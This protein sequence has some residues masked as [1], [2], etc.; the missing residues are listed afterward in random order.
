MGRFTYSQRI[1]FPEVLVSLSK[2]EKVEDKTLNPS[3]DFR[4]R[5]NSQKWL[6][7]RLN[8]AA[9]SLTEPATDPKLFEGINNY[10]HI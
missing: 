8:S 10:Y 9:W 2:C 3:P 1:R 6:E 5:V 7:T 4:I